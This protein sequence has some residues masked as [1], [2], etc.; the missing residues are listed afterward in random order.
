MAVPNTTTRK[1]MSELEQ[2]RGKRFAS[3]ED[4]FEDLDASFRVKVQEA[5]ADTGPAVPHEQVMDE[6]QALIDRKRRARS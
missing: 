5:L 4:L 3:A 2:G 1:A 6:A